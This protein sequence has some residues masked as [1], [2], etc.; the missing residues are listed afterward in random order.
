MGNYPSDKVYPFFVI[1]ESEIIGNNVMVY[2]I[3]WIIDRAAEFIAT[4][5]I[6]L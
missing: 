6:I 4:L 5:M 2:W 1:D 3:F